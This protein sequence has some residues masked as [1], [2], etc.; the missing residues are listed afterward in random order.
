MSSKTDLHV[1]VIGAGII[2]AATAVE[3]L[4]DGQRV[5]LV[6]PGDPGGEQAASNGNGGWLS[7]ASLVPVSTPGLWKMLSGTM[8][9]P[10]APLTVRASYAASALPWV[11]R[12]MFA[13]ATE[14]QVEQAARALCP[15]LADCPE[16]HAALAEEAGVGYLVRHTGLLYLFP[17]RAD[18][19]AES[20]AWR[21][22][23]ELGVQ[24][25]ELD[26]DA[27][28]QREPAL[29]E[30]YRFGVFVEHGAHCI[31]PGAY[32]A[33]LVAH[34]Q[35][36]GAKLV[37]ARAN[38]L[39][40]ERGR[41]RAVSVG[42]ARI[43]CNR[44]VIAAGARSK[45]LAREAGDDVPLESARGYHVEIADPGFEL[46]HT[47]MLS[48]GRMVGTM[49]MQGLRVAGQAELAGLRA[50]PNW[51]RAETLRDHALKAFPALPR[52]LPMDRVRMWMG[53]RPV[54]PDSLP[55]IGPAGFTAD[56]VDCFGHGNIGLAAA[57]LSGR[58]A[59]DLVGGKAPAID[60]TPYAPSRFR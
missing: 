60:P 34:A 51:K 53:H 59:A 38:G 12:F 15:L 29:G 57:A 11:A 56:V 7:P 19:A 1:V 22:R 27:L 16:R 33:A 45:A 26:A 17:S 41:L 46:R 49:T 20:L 10:L 24:W 14:R 18:F 25:V 47:V 55:C 44:A 35:A 2:G 39:V 40:I 28:R 6:E 3:L 30:H 31:D 32:V 8:L 58:L 36:L 37:R 4:R 50:A 42:A 43:A 5:T 9:H 52:N 54:L 23:R 48:D 21:L 13:G